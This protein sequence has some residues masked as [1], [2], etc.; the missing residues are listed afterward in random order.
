MT[1]EMA[2]SIAM[3]ASCIWAV[4]VLLPRAI[5]ERSGLALTSAVLAAVLALIGWLLIGVGV[6]SAAETEARSSAS[7]GSVARAVND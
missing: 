3:L 6:R 7:G 4:R 1:V 2:F 5:K